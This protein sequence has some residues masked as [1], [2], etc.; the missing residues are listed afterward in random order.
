MHLGFDVAMLGQLFCDFQT[1]FKTIPAET[2]KF[3]AQRTK[4]ELSYLIGTRSQCSDILAMAI[5]IS[6]FSTSH[7]ITARPVA[8][9]YGPPGRGSEDKPR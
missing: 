3:G 4:N 5:N 6:I 8:P 1:T 2:P 9:A 7:H